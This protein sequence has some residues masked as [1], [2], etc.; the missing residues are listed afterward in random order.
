MWFWLFKNELGC[1]SYELLH[2]LYQRPYEMWLRLP[3]YVSDSS[4]WLYRPQGERLA[5]WTS[6]T[7]WHRHVHRYS[8]AHSRITPPGPLVVLLGGAA[9]SGQLVVRGSERYHFWVR[10]NNCLYKTPHSTP[11]LCHGDWQLP[12]C[13]IS[14]EPGVWMMP[15]E[16][17][18][19]YEGRA[20]RIR[21]KSLLL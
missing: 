15:T 17:L 8:L 9:C 3:V 18:A 12:R 1:P 7:A 16:P 10:A 4:G 11:S 21:N 20:G 6:Y 14:L 13:P 19:D 2:N 5:A